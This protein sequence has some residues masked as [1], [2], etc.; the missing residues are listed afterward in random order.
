[1]NFILA[2]KNLLLAPF[3]RKPKTVAP[4]VGNTKWDKT[5]LAG[6]IAP[7]L[8]CGG[9]QY[10][11]FH[12]ETD[13]PILR[14]F[15]AQD[16]YSS[17]EV[18]VSRKTISDAVLGLLD[19]LEAKGG[20]LQIGAMVRILD[21]LGAAMNR[22]DN[23]NL[24]LMYKL[25]SVMFFDEGEDPY[26]YSPDYAANKIAHWRAHA[27]EA[28]AFF[29]TLPLG[30]F[31]PLEN[32]SAPDFLTS[33]SNQTRTELALYSVLST[34]LPPTATDAHRKSLIS[35]TEALNKWLESVNLGST[36]TS[37]TNTFTPNASSN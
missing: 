32:I 29:L 27:P 34:N 18:G 5:P 17:L 3:R 35:R 1:M 25:A 9:V 6:K 30:A 21:A 12:R 24:E 13:L 20:K 8:L 7:A 26:T 14:A 16:V 11:C 37:T 36:N 33:L 19:V 2:T 23:Y 28:H 15:E 22:P 31:M 4:E 10:Y